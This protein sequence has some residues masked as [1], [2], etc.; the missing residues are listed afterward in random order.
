MSSS[1]ESHPPG[2]VH[3]S[4]WTKM[5]VPSSDQAGDEASF[6][7]SFAFVPFGHIA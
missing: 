6:M 4:R 3:V 1:L 5:R 2:A 7:I